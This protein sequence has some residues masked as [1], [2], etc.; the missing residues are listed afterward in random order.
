MFF[1]KGYPT[2]L[3][4]PF[5]M[6]TFMMGLPNGEVYMDEYLF[7]RNH[8]SDVQTNGYALIRRWFVAQFPDFRKNPMAYIHTQPEVIHANE[9]AEMAENEMEKVA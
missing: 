7:L 9:F 1:F 6:E 5:A 4:T 3:D 8:A 2:I